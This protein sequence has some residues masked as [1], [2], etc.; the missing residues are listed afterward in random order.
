MAEKTNFMNYS[1]G[2]SIAAPS[3]KLEFF[4]QKHIVLYYILCFTLYH[5]TCIL[6]ACNV[7]VC[8]FDA[9]DCGTESYHNLYAITMNRGVRSYSIPTG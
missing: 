6:Q 5:I 1:V 9:G 4:E 8:G 7:K 3:T 2:F